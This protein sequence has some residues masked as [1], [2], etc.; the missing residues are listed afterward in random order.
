MMSSHEPMLGSCSVPQESR[1][2]LSGG[3]SYAELPLLLVCPQDD[4]IAKGGEFVIVLIQPWSV[5][6]EPSLT[7]LSPV[8]QRQEELISH[9]PAKVTRE[10]DSANSCEEHVLD[11]QVQHCQMPDYHWGCVGQ[12]DTLEMV[13][14]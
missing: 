10:V 12:I 14:G 4:L 5:A 7:L 9:V 13:H 6:D 8:P 1:G 11:H 2:Y 3:V